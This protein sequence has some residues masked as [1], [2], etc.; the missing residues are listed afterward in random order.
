MIELKQ[1]VVSVMGTNS[2][3]L[4][5]K[6]TKAIALVDPGE[7]SENILNDINS[8]GG[9]LQMILL[10][11]GHFDHIGGVAEFL[12]LFP[13]ATVY[14]GE[15]DVECVNNDK[16]NL[17]AKMGRKL[18]EKFPVS[19]LKNN[20]TVLLGNTEIKYVET[21]GHTS[22][23]GLY[24]FEDKILSGDTLFCESCGRTDFP[25]GSSA[26]MIKS[27]RKIA[28]MEGEYTIYPGHEMNTTLSHEKRYNPYMQ[29]NYEDLY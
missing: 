2:F 25:N 28:E 10:T 11:H 7:F 8:F 18:V 26:Q 23:S 6:D 22:G 27:L 4:I 17:S 24:I 19:S 9:N 21:P 15:K 1:Y 20:Q 3:L 29:T 16:L 12:R 5:D 14:V 13:N